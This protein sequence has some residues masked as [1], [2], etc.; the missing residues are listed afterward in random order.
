MLQFGGDAADGSVAANRRLARRLDRRADRTVEP[1]R[2]S[3]QD[4]GLLPSGRYAEKSLPSYGRKLEQRHQ[5]D[6]QHVEQRAPLIHVQF[7]G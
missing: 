4:K 5:A 1:W 3:I 6:Q 7:E 2:A